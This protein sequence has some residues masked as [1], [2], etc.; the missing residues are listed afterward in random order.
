MVND[1][2][3]KIVERIMR[4]DED[5]CFSDMNIQFEKNSKYIKIVLKAVPK[6]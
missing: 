5:Y 1:A 4:I 3:I 2:T 6:K